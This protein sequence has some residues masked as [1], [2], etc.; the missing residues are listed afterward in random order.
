MVD[1]S[2]SLGCSGLVTLDKQGVILEK[3]SRLSGWAVGHRGLYVYMHL[4][5]VFSA[6]STE[7]R[8]RSLG[9]KLLSSSQ[10]CSAPRTCLGF[11]DLVLVRPV[12]S[13]SPPTDTHFPTLCNT[14]T[15][16]LTVELAFTW[17]SSEYLLFCR[18]HPGLGLRTLVPKGFGA[19]ETSR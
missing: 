17:Q 14:T 10:S 6:S 2:G 8:S 7:A 4:P 16:T 19:K 11:S 15:R 9:Q 3:T 12:Y 5:S 1:V 13:I 18:P